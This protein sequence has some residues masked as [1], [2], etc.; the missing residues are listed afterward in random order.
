MEAWGCSV[1]G[2]CSQPVS[3]RCEAQGTRTLRVPQAVVPPLQGRWVE[4]EGLRRWASSSK[5]DKFKQWLLGREKSGDRAGGQGRH[6]SRCGLSTAG[7]GL[8]LSWEV[9]R[10]PPLPKDAPLL[11]LSWGQTREQLMVETLSPSI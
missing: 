2:P 8:L 4:G 5:S 3:G 1:T 9:V 6:T 11:C 10:N 7:A